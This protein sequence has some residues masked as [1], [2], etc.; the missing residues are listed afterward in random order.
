MWIEFWNDQLIYWQDP[1]LLFFQNDLIFSSE[2]EFILRQNK[3][4]ILN[5]LEIWTYFENFEPYRKF[6]V[7]WIN[8][9][10]NKLCVREPYTITMYVCKVV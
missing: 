9:P 7:L 1:F 3:N 2:L 4:Y 8:H 10:V 5:V 6:Y